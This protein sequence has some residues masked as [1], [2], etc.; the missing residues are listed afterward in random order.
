MRIRD[1]F[2]NDIDFTVGDTFVL[3]DGRHVMIEGLNGDTRCV[4]T[5]V[6]F[7]VRK[8]VEFEPYVASSGKLNSASGAC[9]PQL[10]WGENVDI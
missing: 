10:E 7:S 3:A 9:A 1:A 8:Y 2:E 6:D 4:D 5:F